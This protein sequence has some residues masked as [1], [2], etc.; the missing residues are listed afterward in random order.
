M[1]EWI[2]SK[3]SQPRRSSTLAFDS[4]VASSFDGLIYDSYIDLLARLK[5]LIQFGADI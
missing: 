3:N 4:S 1:L 2:G 5:P